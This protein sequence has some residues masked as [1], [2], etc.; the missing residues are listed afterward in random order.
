M[1]GPW[2][3][4]LGCA[5]AIGL[6]GWLGVPWW[7]GIVVGAA[8]GGFQ[9]RSGRQGFLLAGLAGAVAWGAAAAIALAGGGEVVARRVADLLLV[10]RPG[11]LVALTALTGGLTAGLGG[12]TG[13]TLRMAVRPRRQA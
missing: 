6:L 4:A 11:W 7:S 8:F 1:R 3:G 9:A 2:L 5:V 12:L 13:A 10:G